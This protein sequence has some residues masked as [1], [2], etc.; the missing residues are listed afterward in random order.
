MRRLKHTISFLLILLGIQGFAQQ[1]PMFTQYMTNPLTI[2]PAISG[3]RDVKNL[4]LVY[5][6]QWV[7]IEG[8]PKTISL[9]YNG[10]YKTTKVGLG[11]NLIHDR[12]GPVIQ[13][14][15]YLDYAYHL[16]LNEE[17]QYNLSLGIMGGFNYYK[18]DLLSLSVYE[19]D[20]N[21][22]PD[23]KDQKFLPNFGVGLFYYTPK[24]FFGS[25]VPKLLRN[26]FSGSSTD[27]TIEDREERHFFVMTGYI[28]DITNNIKLKPA[29]IGRFVNG[30]PVSLDLTGTVILYDKVWLGLTY[31]LGNALGGIARWQINPKLH[32]G[33]SFDYA[34]SRLRQYNSGTHE[35]FISYDFVPND[36]K[37]TVKRF[38]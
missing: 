27:L 6:Q 11:A 35:I 16:L 37:N 23:G 17:K 14:G 12:I 22:A 24:F 31:R 3:T 18:F 26:S 13:T 20:D 8:A 29:S 4:S 1:D 38:F 5:R 34:T 10:P 36:I 19:P 2:N 25:S 28:F 7:G 21:I 30:A 32:L 33:Y 9:A 15:L